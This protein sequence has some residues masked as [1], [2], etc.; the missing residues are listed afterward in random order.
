[1]KLF[2]SFVR[3]SEEAG[4]RN[5]FSGEQLGRDRQV[6]ALEGH[7]G[8]KYVASV[9]AMAIAKVAKKAPAKDVIAVSEVRVLARLAV[10]ANV[11]VVEAFVGNVMRRG[12][13]IE[14][15]Y[16]QL[17]APSI[18]LLGELWESDEL[19][20]SLLTI[21]CSRLQKV[22]F[23]LEELPSRCS[24]LVTTLEQ[25]RGRIFLSSVPG[26]QHTL[27]V[28]MLADIFRKNGWCVEASFAG[29][30][31][32]ILKAL[33]CAEFDVIGFSIGSAVL[34]PALTS[35]I[36]ALRISKV[37]R[38]TPL[39]VGGPLVAISVGQSRHQGVS[40]FTQVDFLSSDAIAALGWAN[41]QLLKTSN[42]AE[43]PSQVLV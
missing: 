13:Q 36:S 6:Q 40:E 33:D 23:A 18:E 35:L 9:A 16:L 17:L 37:N 32:D 3:L 30:Q 29:N 24:E 2:R 15:I 42:Q 41:A 39:M 20:F 22:I 12:V 26:S 19:N 27:G 10:E 11:S 5:L 21:A 43:T 38:A 7:D 8:K 34:L 28:Q 1:M 14:Q 31:K 25:T 4:V